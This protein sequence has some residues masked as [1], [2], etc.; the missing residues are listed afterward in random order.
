MKSAVHH[1]PANKQQ[2]LSAILEA[3]LHVARP[4]MVI[5]FGS[6]SRGDW[7]DDRYEENDNYPFKSSIIK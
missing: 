2:E 3:V 1:L 7:V 5:L 4:Q 6:F